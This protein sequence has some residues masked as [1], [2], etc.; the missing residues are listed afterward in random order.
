M[1][2][3]ESFRNLKLTEINFFQIRGN[4]FW[5]ICFLVI[6]RFGLPHLLRVKR[7]F[8]DSC[9]EKVIK[10]NVREKRVQKKFLFSPSLVIFLV[11]GARVSYRN[12]NALR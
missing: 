10:K 6:R 1:C 11:H 8:D 5:I 4:Q 2:A 9:L 7:Y 12:A 3:I